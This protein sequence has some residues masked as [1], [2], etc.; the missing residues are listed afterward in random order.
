[1]GVPGFEDRIEMSDWQETTR[2]H[3]GGG[4]FQPP[5]ALPCGRTNDL[6]RRE[7]WLRQFASPLYE[8]AEKM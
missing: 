1:M 3:C 2:L 6:N 5:R 7:L 4:V 8:F